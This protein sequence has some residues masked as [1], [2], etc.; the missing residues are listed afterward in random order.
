MGNQTQWAVHSRLAYKD[1]VEAVGHGCDTVPGRMTLLNAYD[2]AKAAVRYAMGDTETEM[3]QSLKVLIRD[4][5]RPYEPE[6]E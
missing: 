6:D 5:L 4:L 2:K 1:I 3:A